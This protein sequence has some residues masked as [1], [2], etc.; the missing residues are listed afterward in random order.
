MLVRFDRVLMS[1]KVGVGAAPICHERNVRNLRN[2]CLRDGDLHLGVRDL[3][4]GVRD[5]CLGERDLCLG[6]RDLCLGD[7]LIILREILAVNS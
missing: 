1:R 2:L 3:H 4:L 6:E 7:R 5:V